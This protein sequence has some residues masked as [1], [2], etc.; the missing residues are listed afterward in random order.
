LIDI[1]LVLVCGLIVAYL[2]SVFILEEKSSHYGPFP[3]TTERVVWYKNEG[4]GV[5]SEYSYPVTLFDRIRRLYGLFSI[6]QLEPPV[7]ETE[8]ACPTNLAFPNQPAQPSE[9]SKPPVLPVKTNWFVRNERVE[10]WT[11]PKCL[12]FW[13]SLHVAAIVWYWF[14]FQQAFFCLLGAPIVAMVLIYACTALTGIEYWAY[15]LKATV[16]FSAND[17]PADDSD[18]LGI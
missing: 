4:G 16:A 6:A 17:F 11:C 2:T 10:V 9:S 13:V 8:T 1:G 3:S 18:G 14:G 12:S 5:F 15:G 7:E